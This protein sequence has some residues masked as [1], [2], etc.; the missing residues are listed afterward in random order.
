M[1][2]GHVGPGYGLGDHVGQPLFVWGM[3]SRLTKGRSR[4]RS[5]GEG[6]GMDPGRV[7]PGYSLDL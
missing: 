4:F 5:G 3:S 7:G 1:V 6:F 2:P